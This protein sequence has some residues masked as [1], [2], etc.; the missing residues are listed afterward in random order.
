MSRVFQAAL[1]MG[2]TTGRFEVE[3]FAKH[4]PRLS[5]RSSHPDPEVERVGR[6][7]RPSLLF[8]QI[9]AGRPCHSAC[10]NIIL[11]SRRFQESGRQQPW[12]S[13]RPESSS[14]SQPRSAIGER[15]PANRRRNFSSTKVQWRTP[16]PSTSLKKK[17]PPLCSC[18]FATNSTTKRIVFRRL[19]L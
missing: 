6:A 1:G 11:G 8:H 18:E 13:G 9:R 5:L 14:L 4:I 10:I 15:N 7:S 19:A 2:E 16:I 17:G 3:D 12:L